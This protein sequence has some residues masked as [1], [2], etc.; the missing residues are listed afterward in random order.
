MEINDL[1]AA[2]LRVWHAFPRGESVNFRTADDEGTAD[3]ADWGPERTIRATVLRHLLLD[4]PREE[5]EIP[6][7]KL[8]GA[9]ISGTLDLRYASCE[10]AVRLSHCYF[11]GVPQLYGARLRQ[12][13]LGNSVL[14]GLTAGA[15]RVEGVLR[16][17]D[18]LV[19]GV[20]RLG[21]AQIAN[22]LFME[23]THVTA[24]NAPEPALQLNHVTTGDDVWAPG[25]HVE[26]QMRLSGA[27]IA[28]SINMIEARLSLPGGHVLDAETLTVEGD[29]RMRQSR[30]EGW[31]GLRGS[32]IAGRF[33]LS[34]AHMENPGEAALRA[35]SCTI[36]EL[37]LRQGSL[38]GTLNLRRTQ[39][40][41]LFLEP[42][43][44]PGRVRLDNLVYTTLSPHEPAER[45]LPMLER[46]G[47]GYVPHAYEQLTAA[48]RR[49]GDDRAARQVQLAKQLRHRTTLPW[50]GQVWGLLQEVTVGYGFRP[51]RAAVWLLSLLAVGSIAYALH[52]PPP[53]KPSEAPSFN[54]VFYTLDLLLPVISFGQESAF[55][56]EGGYQWLSYVLI[57][58]GWI[59]ATTVVT[60]V[61]RTVSRQ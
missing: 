17:S 34:Y 5:G 31:I 14:P 51:L 37:W 35:S 8:A 20:V 59:L 41:V 19:R 55:A 21:G 46:D 3:G 33:D 52:H 6:A 39:L 16:L 30:V 42:E 26:G 9:R 11:A 36:G 24:V 2:E 57:I 27:A 58:T 56:P 22:A 47:D 7:L 44:V 40:E 38:D 15:L 54:P 4:G 45:R 53:L 60:G 32:R 61:T 1:T 50:Y 29:F 10:H 43:M 23:R 13:N 12:L 28:G 49:V 18:C 48:F 25:L